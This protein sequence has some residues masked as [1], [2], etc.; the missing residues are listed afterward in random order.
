[1]I[2]IQNTHGKETFKIIRQRVL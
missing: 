2:N 1:M